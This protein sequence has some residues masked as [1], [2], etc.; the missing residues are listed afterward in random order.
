[1]SPLT[2]HCTGERA[3]NETSLQSCKA[4]DSPARILT[5]PRSV[6][7]ISKKI[8]IQICLNSRF[9]A[10][11]PPWITFT[12]LYQAR[13][14]VINH[15][16]ITFLRVTLYSCLMKMEMISLLEAEK[17]KNFCKN[18]RL[19]VPNNQQSTLREGQCR[20]NQS[21]IAKCSQSPQKP[22]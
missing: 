19:Q 7:L 13:P 3:V 2:Q 5:C 16:T 18:K 15:E 6:E 12:L 4:S 8:H 21:C 11:K 22:V 1:M 9:I 14:N 20:T 10:D 17:K